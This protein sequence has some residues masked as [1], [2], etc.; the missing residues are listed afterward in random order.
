MEVH[1]MVERRTETVQEG[2]GAQPRAGGCGRVGGPGDACG[3]AQ[4]PL[5][6]IKKD[7]RE[8]RDGR[9]AVGKHA[10][11]SLGHGDHPL[12]HGH[13]WNHVID[14]MRGGL[15]HVAAVAGR[16]DAPA[17][18]GER[19]H[20]RLAAACAQGTGESEAEDAALE[21]AAEFLRDVARHGPLGGFPPGEPALE[22]L[23]DDFVER[24]L[25]GAAALVAP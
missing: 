16:A 4:Q 20:E 11:Q 22:V 15:G 17:L 14:E 2:D 5:D 18:A 7:L 9:G 25:L 24:R 23:R 12:P 3:S 13:G 1:V 8:G 19:H 10:A 21:I 6:L